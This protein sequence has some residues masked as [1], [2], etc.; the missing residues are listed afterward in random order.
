MTSLIQAQQIEHKGT[1]TQTMLR[2]DCKLTVRL[3][4]LLSAP[5]TNLPFT[6]PA[7][8]AVPAEGTTNQ[9]ST[10]VPVDIGVRGLMVPTAGIACSAA[11]VA[12][13]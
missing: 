7:V 8:P 9:Y 10:E 11:Q 6:K 1:H 12:D 2:P 5:H 3:L 13:C 4:V